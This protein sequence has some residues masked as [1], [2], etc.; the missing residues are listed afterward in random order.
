MG[1]LLLDMIATPMAMG[2]DSQGLE[3]IHYWTQVELLKLIQL[4]SELNELDC[5]HL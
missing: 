4:K 5:T 3:M 2:M 1:M